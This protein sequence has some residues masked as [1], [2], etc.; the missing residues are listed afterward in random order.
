MGATDLADSYYHFS[1]GKMYQFRESY[2]LALKEYQEALKTDPES[3]EVRLAM[4]ETMFEMGDISKAVSMLQG[5]VQSEPENLDAHLMLGR[6]FSEARSQDD[7]RKKA[8]AEFEKALELDSKNLEALQNA[9]ELRGADGDFEKAVEYYERFREEVPN[10]IGA[11]YSEAEALIALNRLDDAIKVLKVGLEIRDDIPDYV[12]RL[13]QLLTRQGR[14]DEAIEVYQRGLNNGS[15]RGD[16]R[17][18]MGLAEVYL[19]V[20][21][22]SDAAPLLEKLSAAQPA[23]AEV[24]Y[25]LARAYLDTNRLNDAQ[26]IL[27]DLEKQSD[28]TSNPSSVEVGIALA[29]TLAGQGE[30]DQAADKVEGLLKSDT[31][32]DPA[33]HLLL[34]KNLALLRERQS[35]RAESRR[36]EAID[37]LKQVIEADPQDMTAKL[38]LVEMYSRASRNDEA[39]ALS[40]SLLDAQPDD[41]YVLIARARALAAAGKVDEGVGLLENHTQGSSH[42]ELLYLA[43]S[44]IYLARDQFDG[45]Q[46]V[47]EH[48]LTVVP[49]SQELR[50]Q[51]GAIYERQ[52]NYGAAENE[53][54][55]VL[56]ARP[57]YAEALNYL[58][59]MLAERGVRLSEA[60]D[61]VKRA[62]ELEPHNGAFLDSLGWVYF[63]QDNLEKAEV[64]LREA[65]R[66]ESTDST[67]LEHLG[68]LYARK[69]DVESARRFYQ[70]SIRYSD[71]DEDSRRVQQ[72]L[73]KLVPASPGS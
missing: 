51:L 5:V 21:K 17:L 49:S 44:Q 10:S 6:I 59:Y 66:L 38:Q 9:A 32:Q 19:R 64:H 57:D 27:E 18:Q 25:D 23:D 72:K 33:I 67:I 69:G 45:A 36:A 31:P 8:L 24:R 2:P 16:G 65:A 20:G 41:P 63:K 7:M 56:D 47:V 52:A 55:Q 29:N 73:E 1:L 34:L 12:L 70:D 35:R 11:C 68:D 39:L 58:G 62:V 28:A 61:Y 46:R 22:G 54:K 4:A 13:A 14:F 43:A 26:K 3:A 71:R 37:L 60:L 40:K 48:G 42:A 15:G 50:F 30:I 53:F